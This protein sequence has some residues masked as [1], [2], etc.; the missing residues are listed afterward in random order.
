M[1]FLLKK[2]LEKLLLAL[3]EEFWRNVRV[4]MEFTVELLVD[5]MSGNTPERNPER[6][7]KAFPTQFLDE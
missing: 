3:I 2:F 1:M 7:L 5:K 4:K 6:I